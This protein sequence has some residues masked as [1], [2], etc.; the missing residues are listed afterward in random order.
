M[1]KNPDPQ[2]PGVGQNMGSGP[3]K[4]VHKAAAGGAMKFKQAMGNP[5]GLIMKKQVPPAE[6]KTDLNKVTVQS[7]KDNKRKSK[8]ES[9]P[10][11][12]P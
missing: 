5:S 11:G 2:K 9:T 6:V 8:N 3:I 1:P 12:K 7:G 10:G 4:A